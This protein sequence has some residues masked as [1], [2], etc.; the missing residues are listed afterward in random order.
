VV[1]G[2][3][4]SG[5]GVGLDGAMGDYCLVDVVDVGVHG[6]YLLGL[7]FDELS[8]ALVEEELLFE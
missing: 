5:G 7:V 4:L 3:A 6:G 2:A 8:V 1:E